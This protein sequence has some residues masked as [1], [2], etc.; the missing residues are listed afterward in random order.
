MDDD[1]LCSMLIKC[2]TFITG[3]YT[4]KALAPWG[5]FSQLNELQ[6]CMHCYFIIIM[7]GM[8]RNVLNSS[9][10]DALYLLALR[11]FLFSSQPLMNF[12]VIEHLHANDHFSCYFFAWCV[13]AH[14]FRIDCTSVWMYGKYAQKRRR[15]KL[16]FDEL[17]AKQLL[18]HIIHYTAKRNRIA[19]AF[20]S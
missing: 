9:A 4:K 10:C 3:T 13:T 11:T 1:W 5:R 17:H 18:K 20:S 15:W 7:N 2:A 19:Y 8:Q 16:L 14:L 12:S 6:F